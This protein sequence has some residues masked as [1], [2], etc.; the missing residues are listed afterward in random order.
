MR[1]YVFGAVFLVFSF[2]VS[3]DSYIYSKDIVGKWQSNEYV[4]GK[5]LN[6]RVFINE[7]LSFE[8]TYFVNGVEDDD[9]SFRGSYEIPEDDYVII[10]KPD[11]ETRELVFRNFMLADGAR[12]LLLVDTATPAGYK[13]KRFMEVKE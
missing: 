2:L 7:D 3:C 9:L 13:G 4:S 1:L 12:A 5:K 8:W 10:F 11:D 6:Q